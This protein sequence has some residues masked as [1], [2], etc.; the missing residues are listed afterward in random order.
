M[1]GN[2]DEVCA[3]KGMRYPINGVGVPLCSC[4]NFV[5]IGSHVCIE[6]GLIFKNG[7]DGS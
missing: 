4:Q 1:K 2:L 5:N 7:N 3:R 6:G